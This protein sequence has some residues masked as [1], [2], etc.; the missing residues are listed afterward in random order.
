MI[1]LP[2]HATAEVYREDA[3]PVYQVR[4]STH[5]ILFEPR[6]ML[7]IPL[8]YSVDHVLM[9][10]L[11]AGYPLTPLFRE[12]A[13]SIEAQKLDVRGIR[14]PDIEVGISYAFAV[15]HPWSRV[16]AGARY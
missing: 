14:I 15:S 7:G 16:E 10:H 2:I 1:G 13:I 5:N 11:S 3:S 6:V 8:S 9:A 4:S 12:D